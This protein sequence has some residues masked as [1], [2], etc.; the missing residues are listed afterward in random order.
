M[1]NISTS[2]NGSFAKPRRNL[3]SG[4]LGNISIAWKMALMVFVL[5]L[6]ILGITVS[7][8]V[9][10]QSL[11]YQFSNI[12]DF[13]LI[14]I[15]S[16]EN[17]GTFLAE[18]QRY[19]VQSTNW[20]I[21]TEERTNSL[22]QVQ[23]DNQAIEKII[24]R[25]DKEWV[26]TTSPQFTQDLK[27]G[28]KID[29]QLQ[30][31]ADLAAYHKAHDAY[32]TTFAKYQATVQTG[33]PD[34]NLA[35][36]AIT[37]LEAAQTQLQSL[38][39][40][41][42]KFADFSNLQAQ[43]AF[44]QALVSSGVVL[45]LG[46]VIG[47]VMSYLIA[48]SVTNRLGVLT[49]SAA[50]MQEGNLDQIVSISGN[51][52][53]SLLGTTFNS[54]IAQLKNL[55]ST[56]E[57]R[58]A[59]RTQSLELAADVGR[60]VSR[61]RALVVMLKDATELIR[62]RFDLYYTQVYLADASQTN[63]ILQAG[64]GNV[65]AELISRRHSLPLDTTSINGRAAVEKHSVVISD[66]AASSTFRPNPL[67]PD[68]RSEMAVPLL[69]GDRVAGV[70]NLQSQKAGAL[71]LD[72]LPAFEAL[73]GQLA[74]AIQNANLLA[75]TEQARAE[76][77]KQAAR[78]TRAN[79]QDYL[80]AIHQPEQIGFLY[81]QNKV[82]A[83]A[84]VEDFQ[85]SADSNAVTAPISIT[86]EVLGSLV[87]EMDKEKQSARA[88][89]LV[90]IAARQVAQ[91]IENLRLLDSAER[92]RAE[93]EEAARRLTREGWKTYTENTGES[94][95]YLYDLREMRPL[96]GRGSDESATTVPLKVHDE[97]IGKLAVQGLNTDDKEAMD[98]A[99]AVAERL[100]AHIE[101]LRQFEETKRSQV[102]LDKRAQ[103]LAAV[104]E[105]STVSSKELDIQ[106]MLESVVY[107]TQRQF[108]LYHAHVFI[109]NEN[110]DILK[111]A[112]CGW[113]E[114]D[115]HEGTHGTAAIPL[116]QEQSLVARTARTRQAVIVNNVHNEPGWLPDPL[117]PDTASELAVPLVI[118]DQLLG[119]LDVQ[120]DR[121]NAFTEEDANIQTTL[122][123]QVATAL[124]NAR[125]FVR[126]QKQAERES[127][128]NAISQKIQSATTVEAVLQIAARELGHALGAPMTIA[129]LSMKDKN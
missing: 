1:N 101:S 23:V 107:L 90:N 78:L 113:K 11:Q 19:L 46:L 72:V 118:G 68:T 38:I 48:V 61:V 17:A 40:V 100:S 45:A 8:Y 52:E 6:S 20:N 112:A 125:S 89:E 25:Y 50:A 99:N 82:V 5:F 39:D 122:A 93:A 102:E 73:A 111:I 106:K 32:K 9:G 16:I 30:E 91:Q 84:E 121:I 80:D 77:E 74:I 69:I 49:R 94:L 95:S 108:G 42:L 67:L 28:G 34:A 41:N 114:G 88:T 53:V 64:T 37:Q 15:S 62:S 66:T 26:T 44:N 24:T 59:E 14:P 13:M 103:Q 109:Y 104:A 43:Q 2:K 83:L 57:A 31:V 75:E 21:T 128:L 58:V 76:V 51:D 63:L 47:L 86:G 22:A 85:P 96:N 29:L 87:V 7:A 117:L 33:S 124:Q 129:Q 98:L 55:F 3:L 79:W 4:F 115:P 81:D 65:G 97:M 35:S 56:L 18:A 27:N 119:V 126:A 12:Y 10:L 60:S 120:A 71:S 54:M 105:I 110:T 127:T 92:Y 36:D 123:S 70:L 116:T